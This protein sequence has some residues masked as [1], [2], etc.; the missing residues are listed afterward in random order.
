MTSL[1]IS[2]MTSLLRYYK[3]LMA[4]NKRGAGSITFNL[5]TRILKL[6]CCTRRF[7]E[8]GGDEAGAA[9]TPALVVPNGKQPTDYRFDL[10]TLKWV[11]ASI[12]LS[13]AEMLRHHARRSAV[14]AFLGMDGSSI[15]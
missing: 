2:L 1:M 10:A 11:A 15:R 7:N 13:Q 8:N 9:I 14:D 6:V 3:V 4:S 5:E 12:P